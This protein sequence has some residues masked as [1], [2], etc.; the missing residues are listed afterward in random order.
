MSFAMFEPF[1][2]TP[3]KSHGDCDEDCDECFTP[4][5]KRLRPLA[6][7][8]RRGTVLLSESPLVCV[9]SLD[10]TARSLVCHHCARPAA[11]LEAEFA[12]AARSHRRTCLLYTSPSPR[13]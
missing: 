2:T 13:D 3:A 4:R 8:R 5:S 11:S 7:P 1:P 9:Q 10:S 12:L 6:E